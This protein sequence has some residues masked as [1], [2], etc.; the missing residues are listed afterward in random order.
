MA[1]VGESS[2]GA[3]KDIIFKRNT[4]PQ[5]NATLDGTA[6][7]YLNIVL[8]EYMRANVTVTADQC[9]GQDHDKLPDCRAFTDLLALDVR[10]RV[11]HEFFRN[12]S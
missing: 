1:V 6:V 2:I 12:V 9:T 4:V 10:A 7:T 5:L 11:N 8:N 3:D